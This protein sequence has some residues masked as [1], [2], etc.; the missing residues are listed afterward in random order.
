MHA[1]HQPKPQEQPE[2]ADKPLKQP[3]VVPG[4]LRSKKSTK[5]ISEQTGAQYD[6]QNRN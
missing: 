4:Y 6:A 2:P 5:V 1:A 3:Q